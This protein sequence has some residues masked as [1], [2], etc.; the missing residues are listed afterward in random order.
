MRRGCET[1]TIVSKGELAHRDSTGEGGTI[2]PGDV[3]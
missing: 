3:Q 1:V 2:G